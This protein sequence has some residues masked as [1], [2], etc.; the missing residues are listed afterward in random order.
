MSTIVPVGVDQTSRGKR[1]LD[2]S[3]RLL[4]ELIVFLGTAIDNEIAS[5]IIA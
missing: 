1:A 5:R 2:I 4:A 3:S